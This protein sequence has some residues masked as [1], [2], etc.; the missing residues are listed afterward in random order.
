V[1]EAYAEL[2][3]QSRETAPQVEERLTRAAGS[4]LVQDPLGAE[5]VKVWE[6]RR[7]YERAVKIPQDLAVA[8]ARAA[9]ELG[10]L[11]GRVAWGRLEEFLDWLRQK[12]QAPGSS[13]WPRQLVQE[14]TG[15]DLKAACL[16][17]YLR[18]KLGALSGFYAVIERKGFFTL[19]K[20]AAR[21]PLKITVT[22]LPY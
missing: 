17:D 2:V 21:R 4:A 18:R 3:E 14:V 16:L 13:S 20:K 15:E 8:L 7:A 9:A 6:W 1:G 22:D 10:D 5:A 19:K 12:I 11:A